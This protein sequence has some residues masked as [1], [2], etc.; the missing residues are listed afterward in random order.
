MAAGCVALA[1]KALWRGVLTA[2]GGLRVRGTA[3][4]P[5]GPCV[6]VANH[7]S[8][9]DT[10][11]LIAALP[12]RRRPAVAA[13][14]D[15]WF[16]GSATG[17]RALLSGA[18]L[19][20]WACQALCGAFPVRRGGGGTADLE[21]AARLLAAGR[22]VVVYPEGS[23]SRDG[24][25]GAFRHGAARLAATA[26]VPL[27]PAGITG[28]RALL[29]PAGTGV[30]RRRARVTVR[31]GVPVQ[32]RTAIE[33]AAGAGVAP[34]AVASNVVAC[35]AASS[36]VAPS[37]VAPSDVAP[38]VV[39]TATD[40][41]RAQVLGLSSSPA[42]HVL[43]LHER[44]AAF[45]A[46]WGG[47]ALVAGWAFGE[48]LSWPFLP[49]LALA[50]LCVAA[51][52]AGIRVSAGAA[53]GSVSGG[54][55]GYLLAAHGITLPEPVTTARMHAAVAAQVTAHGAAA[56]LAQPLSGIP[57]KVYVAAS[58]ARHVGLARFLL[59]SVEARGTRILVA[60]LVMTGVGACV[61]RWR[62]FYPA[63]LL[64]V[65]GVYLGG[66]AAVVASW[67]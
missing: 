42:R 43:R 47:L 37:V 14:A 39:A 27:V 58:G 49:E 44:V 19:R 36:D 24:T 41:A 22:D 40:E 16:D 48:A 57:F 52:R 29:P 20:P 33:P 60:G 12:A 38:S 56:I 10:A 25:V 8:H 62:R 3:R 34:A 53:I 5:E 50:V 54:V 67:S 66:W 13:A 1:R 21:A 46:S 23:R 59:D 2:T 15:Y 6:I 18:R 61:Q 65:A 31:I 45:A 26:G 17:P 7:S 64:L 55:A 28:T 63:Y 9:A 51:P 30:R 11:A 32:T 4:L 35:L